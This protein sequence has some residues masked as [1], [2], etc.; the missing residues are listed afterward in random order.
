MRAVT[1]NEYGGTPVVAEVPTPQP[2]PGQVRIKLH[3]AGMNPMDRTLA[4][5][6]WKPAPAIFPMVLG[7]MARA[8]ST[9]SA[10]GPRG[11]PPA[12]SSSASC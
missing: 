7:A 12:T 8:S 5:G 6:D 11:S 2:G 4:A 3:A 1:V 9:R 10:R